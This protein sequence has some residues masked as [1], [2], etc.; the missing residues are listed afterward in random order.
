LQ[1]IFWENRSRISSGGKH[2]KHWVR[3][4]KTA[5]AAKPVSFY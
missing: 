2:A 5:L 1:G 4:L 3:A